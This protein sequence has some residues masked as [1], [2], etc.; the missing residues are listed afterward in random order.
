VGATA[1]LSASLKSSA[2]SLLGKVPQP[3]WLVPDLACLAGNQGHP[4]SAAI[5]LSVKKGL[6]V[7]GFV[8][9]EKLNQAYA[10]LYGLAPGGAPD[11]AIPDSV[12]FAGIG[13]TLISAVLIFLMALAI[14]NHFRI[15]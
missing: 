8:A 9:P 13:Q 5:L 1:W 11:P 7:L 14:R 2:A 3:G 6:L 12:A 4:L 15:K 10:C